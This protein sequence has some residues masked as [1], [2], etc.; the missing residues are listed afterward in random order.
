MLR[1]AGLAAVVVVAAACGPEIVQAGPGE[2]AEGFT[3]VVVTVSATTTAADGDSLFS[4]GDCLTWDQGDDDAAFAT[5]PCDEP[6]LVEVTSPVDLS[7]DFAD[8]A[9]L[10]STAE[11]RAFAD[12]RCLPL[13]EFYLARALADEEPGIILPSTA[14]WEA[15]DR[16]GY[17]TV[18][19][20]RVGGDRP[21]YT[22]SRRDAAA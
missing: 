22:G 20:A 16:Q 6:H 11:L 18:G 5:V 8:G 3:D 10:P 7:D 14:A 2:P 4:V 12:D 15:G 9:D 19:L 21:A 13:A 1:A 17:C